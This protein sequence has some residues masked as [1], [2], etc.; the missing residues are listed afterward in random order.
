MTQELI[1]A[2]ADGVIV[3]EDPM[4]AEYVTE[5]YTKALTAVIKA[6]PNIVLLAQT[7]SEETSL[8]E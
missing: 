4:L 1:E 7:P 6:D 2:G 5:P 3:V 8:Q